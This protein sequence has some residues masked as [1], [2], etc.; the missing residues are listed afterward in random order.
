MWS[1]CVAAVCKALLPVERLMYG[2]VL[3]PLPPFCIG[4]SR[5]Q[6]DPHRRC[7]VHRD[8]AGRAFHGGVRFLVPTGRLVPAGRVL[9]QGTHSPWVL[10]SRPRC[11]RP[12]KWHEEISQK[13]WCP[14]NSDPLTPPSHPFREMRTNAPRAHICRQGTWGERPCGSSAQ[15][16]PCSPA[17]TDM[18]RAQSQPPA[19]PLASATPPAPWWVRRHS[20]C[21]IAHTNTN[22]T[23]FPGVEALGVKAYARRLVAAR[24][25]SPTFARAPQAAIPA[26]AP[27][28]TTARTD[29]PAQAGVVPPVLRV[30]PS[31]VLHL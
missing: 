17:E 11:F 25:N 19:A 9:Y 22:T 3:V 28:P 20:A 24:P 14:L 4:G 10:T 13:G 23:R 21:V 27:A 12:T 8:G 30:L 2:G 31:K 6:S 7:R 1:T 18:M 15:R 26:P 5:L 29:L 16:R